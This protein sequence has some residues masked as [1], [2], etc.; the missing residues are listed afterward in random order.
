[1]KSRGENRGAK[2]LGV[3]GSSGYRDV[4]GEA[5]STGVEGCLEEG[6]GRAGLACWGS[7]LGEGSCWVQQ[8]PCWVL[9]TWQGGLGVGLQGRDLGFVPTYEAMGL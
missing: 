7:C 3:V 5:S 8:D 6:A 1:M 2:S 4:P 9:G